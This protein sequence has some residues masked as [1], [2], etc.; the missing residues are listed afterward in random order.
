MSSGEA[1]IGGGALSNGSGSV[2][3]DTLIED[4]GDSTSSGLWPSSSSLPDR[5]RGGSDSSP[6]SDRVYE[7]IEPTVFID[8]SRLNPRRRIFCTARITVLR[9]H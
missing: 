5:M 2:P 4:P 3:G 8:A 9:G 1:T 6:S 7:T